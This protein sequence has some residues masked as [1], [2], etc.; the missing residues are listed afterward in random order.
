MLNVDPEAPKDSVNAD[1]TTTEI[2][3]IS[4]KDVNPSQNPAKAMPTVVLTPSAME[5]FASLLVQLTETAVFLKYASEVSVL[6][7]ATLQ[8]R[9]VSMPVRR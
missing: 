5:R 8:A 4:F 1:Q 3:R 2:Q 6:M 7:L 9:V